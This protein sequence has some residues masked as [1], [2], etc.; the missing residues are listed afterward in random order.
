VRFKDFPRA[1]TV[2]LLEKITSL[3]IATAMGRKRKAEVLAE[4]SK[5]KFVFNKRG[6]LMR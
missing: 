6:K 1:I 2:R 5:S 3:E 4:G